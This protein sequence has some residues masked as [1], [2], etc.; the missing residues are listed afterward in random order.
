MYIGGEARWYIALCIVSVTAVTV[1][2]AGRQDRMRQGETKVILPA[3]FGAWHKVRDVTFED[4][5]LQT[6][7]TKDVVG[8]I[9]EG[10]G[11][12]EVELVIVQATN[13]RTAFHP[14]E[15]CLTGGGSEI[16]ERRTGRNPGGF[17]MNEMVLRTRTGQRMLVW[18]WYVSGG[19]ATANFY[20]QQLQLFIDQV[21]RGGN[22]GTAVNIYSVV[23]GRSVDG[24]RQ[25]CDDFVRSLLP[26]ITPYL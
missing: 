20:R 1:L 21:F 23:S 11:H 16:I 2:L 17:S 19:K 8:G 5:I 3:S 26:V 9:F 24:Q 15:Y 10:P 6:L 18:N 13:N 14:P 25:V 22:K 12:S 4:R 7:G